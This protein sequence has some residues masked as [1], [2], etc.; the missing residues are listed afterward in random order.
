MD[1]RMTI[2]LQSGESFAFQLA[3]N[4]L[5]IGV[6]AEMPVTVFGAGWGAERFVR[7]RMD[8][9]QT[10]SFAVNRRTV[11]R[12]RL[13]AHGTGDP[14]AYLRKMKAAGDV[15][16]YLCSFTVKALDL[17]EADFVPEVDG[18]MGMTAFLLDHVAKGTINLTF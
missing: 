12:D 5:G 3:L 17:P 16:I 9:L 18:L 7:G 8:T 11:I 14:E 15:R 13:A 2:C 4:A 1:Q 10:P 6:A